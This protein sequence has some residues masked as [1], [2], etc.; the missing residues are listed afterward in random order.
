MLPSLEGERPGRLDNKQTRRLAPSGWAAHGV[1]VKNHALG[2]VS[3]VTQRVQSAHG[4]VPSTW[5]GGTC[6]WSRDISAS[7]DIPA[8]RAM[9]IRVRLN[10]YSLERERDMNFSQSNFSPEQC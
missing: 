9:P 1:T 5:L 3:Q 10:S 2:S 8:K 4:P 6:A 7:L